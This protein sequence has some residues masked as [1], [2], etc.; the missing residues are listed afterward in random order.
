M[1]LSAV[2]DSA[3]SRAALSQ[4]ERCLGQFEVK[5]KCCPGLVRTFFTVYF[6]SL[7]ILIRYSNLQT[8]DVSRIL[9]HEK[10]IDVGQPAEAFLPSV[11]V[12]YS[13]AD[14]VLV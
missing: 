6:S 4:D 10:C 14:M 12:S 9:F 11:A 5:A 8:L 7:K 1:E 2:R 3:E 13:H